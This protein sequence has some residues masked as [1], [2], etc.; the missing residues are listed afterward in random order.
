MS[1]TKQSSIEWYIQ[2][3]HNIEILIQEGVIH[4]SQYS[5][6]KNN[7]LKKAQKMNKQ[8]L[9]SSYIDGNYDNGMGRCEPE[10][11]YS[12]TYGGNK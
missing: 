10:Q 1:N 3:I 8:E 12:E 7:A 9:I 5:G 11:W 2:E 6:K 4:S